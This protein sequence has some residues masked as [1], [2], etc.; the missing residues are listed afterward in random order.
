MKIA[1]GETPNIAARVQGKAEPDEVAISAATQRLVTGLFGTEDRGRHELRGISRPQLLY[2]VVAEIP[3]QSRFAVAIQAGLTPLA[4]REHELDVL[5]ERWTSAQA[6]AGQVV[7]LSGEPGIGKSRLVQELTDQTS[8]DGATRIVLQCSPYHQNSALYP[9]IAYFE[10][11]LE[12]APEDTPQTKLAKLQQMLGRHRFPPPDTVALFAALL[13][14]PH[15]EG[16]PPLTVSPQK[17]KEQTHEAVVDW[18]I[19]ETEQQPVYTA[20]EDLHWADPSTLE[21]L[22]TCPFHCSCL[23]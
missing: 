16:A 8:Q 2:R 22:G 23:N 20:W 13:S 21:V 12:F 19:E 17:Q 15:P 9:L 6:G 14:L 4:G 18:L 3:T 11:L 7:L 5:S 1:I 10:R